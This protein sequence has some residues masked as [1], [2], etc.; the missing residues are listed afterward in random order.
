[1]KIKLLI[2]ISC[3]FLTWVVNAQSFSE[4][5]NEKAFFYIMAI[6]NL[7]PTDALKAKDYIDFYGC[8]FDTYDYKNST[9][10]EFE[11]NSYRERIKT[12]ILA[13]I[14]KVN[15]ND[16]F[17]STGNLM[18]GE[19][20]FS[21]HFFPITSFGSQLDISICCP[22]YNGVSSCPI[23]IYMNGLKEQVINKNNFNWALKMSEEEASAFIKRR[24][25]NN[26]DIDRKVYC[27]ITYS[28]V[29]EK[30]SYY[31]AHRFKS[32]FYSI[33]VYEDSYLTKKIGSLPIINNNATPN[34]YIKSNLSKPIEETKKDNT[35][36]GCT[37]TNF[38]SNSKIDSKINVGDKYAGG[39]VFYLDETGQHGLVSAETDQSRK[40]RWGC[41]TTLIGTSNNVGCGEQN[42][43]A[44][45]AKC[46]DAVFAAK[47]CDDLVLNGYNDWFLPSL[48]EL[49][50]M[51][52]LKTILGMS[53]GIEY[54][55]SS[56]NGQFRAW[57]IGTNSSFNL[58]NNKE[59]DYAVRAVRAF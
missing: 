21:D 5:T 44:I 55:S 28:I 34:D 17:S 59:F 41:S 25:D 20:S 4:I 2:A 38:L 1:M 31:D 23:R 8:S 30:Y 16:K 12:K 15:F 9:K 13:G 11:K 45:V 58:N 51:K 24:K 40:A 52:R 26:G 6:N 22:G 18:L 37:P 3:C 54:M 48:E 35:L 29:S 42:T 46:Y 53:P 49:I 56:E 19:Y 14:N 36:N 32:F 57:G 43:K 27:R 33:D 47:I 50:L 39:I 10:D 7:K